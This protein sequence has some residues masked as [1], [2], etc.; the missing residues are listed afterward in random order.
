VRPFHFTATTTGKRVRN[1][2]DKE[3]PIFLSILRG[4]KTTDVASLMRSVE[5][6]CSTKGAEG[7]AIMSIPRS[8]RHSWT[9]AFLAQGKEL[10]PGLPSSVKPNKG[11][12][13][14]VLPPDVGDV[15][16]C[17]SIIFFYTV[18]YIHTYMYIYTLICVLNSFLPYPTQ[19][20][21]EVAALIEA[22]LAIAEVGQDVRHILAFFTG[23][24]E[25]KTH[26]RWNACITNYN[27]SRATPF[28]PNEEWMRTQLH[29]WGLTPRAGT[30]VAR[31]LPPNVDEVHE[32]FIDRLAFLI[33]HDLPSGVTMTKGGVRVPVTMIPPVLVVNCDQGGIPPIS[34]LSST[35]AK[36]GVKDVPLVGLDDKRQMTAVLGSS[37]TGKPLPLQVVMQG[38]SDR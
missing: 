24:L 31:K 28:K 13:K 20:E 23:V 27:R 8:T 33:R 25:A 21:K 15:G 3:K 30:T 22:H 19:V 5:T 4:F 1:N 2:Y 11:G 9:K 17:M 7:K 6:H 36:V 32:Q 35:W 16:A 38:Q 10:A 14:P 18:I 34:F 26:P 37:A 29:K 12:R